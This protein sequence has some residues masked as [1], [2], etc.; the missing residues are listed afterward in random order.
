MVN[1]EMQTSSND[2]TLSTNEKSKIVTTNEN[3]EIIV[4]G[5]TI[6]QVYNLFEIKAEGYYDDYY[7]RFVIVNNEGKYEISIE[8]DWCVTN[9]ETT[10]ENGIPTI[11]LTIENDKIPTYDLQIV[12]IKKTTEST[13]SGDEKIANAE[14]DL[15]SPEVEYL[16]GA[17]F[18]LYKGTELIGD[19]TTDSQGKITIPGLY[20]YEG[21]I[22]YDQ[23]YTLK[24]VQAPSGY[25]KVQDIT[26]RAENQDGKI[27]LKEIAENGKEIESERYSIEGNTVQLI[28]EDSPSFK[29]IKKDGETKE[30]L[31]GVKFAIYNVENEQEPAR[32]SKGEIIGTK[33][34]INGEEYY[35]VE[36]NAQGEITEDL[37]AGLY[38][39]VEVQ[40]DEKYDILGNVYYFGI[41][42]SRE[43]ETKMMPTYAESIG[44]NTIVEINS[45]IDTSDGGYLVGGTFNNGKIDFGDYE[46]S[47][48]G[49]TDGFIVKY[50]ANNE[51]EWANNIGGTGNEYIYSVTET[52][53]NE[54]V[55]VGYI[56]STTVQVGDYKLDCQGSADGM[57]AKY[58]SKGEVI[59]ATNIGQKDWDEFNSVAATSDGGFVI[60]GSFNNNNITVG[61]DTYFNKGRYDGLIIKYDSSNNVAWATTIGGNSWD[62]FNSIAATSDGG[63]VIA[64]SFSSDSITIGNTSIETKGTY[65]GITI[66]YDSN[67]NVEWT[68][69]IGGSSRDEITTIDETTDG[70]IVVGGKFQS[71]NITI[72]NYTL[73]NKGSTIYN[74]GFIAKYDKE[75]EVVWANN[76]GGSNNDYVSTI[77]ATPD[78][79]ILVGGDFVSSSITIGNEQLNNSNNSN[80]SD[81]FI[82]KLDVNGQVDW[83][84]SIKGTN[85]ENVYSVLVTNNEDYLILGKTVSG[86][87]EADG[88]VLNN[89]GNG[90]GFLFKYSEKEIDS[91]ISFATTVGGNGYDEIS[92]VVE[93]V[94]KGYIVGGYF[95]KP[96]DLGGYILNNQ[97]NY[98]GMLIKYNAKGKVE[99]ATNIG[100][101]GQD[102]VT[103]IAV[104]KD[105][106]YIVGGY[107]YSDEIHV[108]DY[109]LTRTGNSG[110]SDGM[111]IKYNAKGQVEWATSIGSLGGFDWDS[112]EKVATTSDEGYIVGG[113]YQGS[114]IQVGDNTFNNN[115]NSIRSILI[116]YD[117]YGEVEWASSTNRIKNNN[118]I[119]VVAET[120]D[121]G[122]I[123]GNSETIIKYSHSGEELWKIIVS[124][125]KNVNVNSIVETEDGGYVVVGDFSNESLTVGDYTLE[126]KGSSDGFVIKYSSIGEVEWATSI[127]E[128]GNDKVLSA[129]KTKD[130]GC[131]VGGL[132]SNKNLTV[133]DYI[134]ENQGS[135]D[136][137]IIKYSSSGEVKWA[138]SFGGT[139][140]DQ[141]GSL[142]ETSDG[143]YIIGGNFNSSNISIGDYTIKNNG[144]NDGFLIKVYQNNS[145]P[146]VQELTVENNRKE[147]QITT[148]VNEINGVKGGNISGENENPYETIKHGDSTTK[149]II[150]NP[151]DGYEIIGITV[152]G[153]EYPFKA[154]SDGT[155]TM[156]VF[157]NVTENKHIE[158]TYAL[159]SNKITI[160]KIDSKTKE[161][162]SGVKFRIERIDGESTT[163]AIEI[164]TNNEGKAITQLEYGRYQITEL[165]TA[166]G[167]ELLA[168]PITVDFTRDGNSIVE[169]DNNVNV[170][171][172]E[173]GE[174][175]IEN[176]ETAK[177]IVHH[178]LKD[179]DGTYTKTKVA[180]DEIIE[181]TDKD[182]Y[183]TSPKVDLEKYELEKD[184]NGA[185]VIPKNAIGN[186]IPEETIEVTYYY[187]SK[188]IP[189]TVHYYI[190]GTEEEVPLAN[191]GT[192][193]DK[194]YVGEEGEKYTTSSISENE[195]DERYEL[196]EVPQNATGIYEYNEVIVTYYYR[197]KQSRLL[198]QKVDDSGEAVSGVTLKIVNK[199]TLREWIYE[200]DENGIIDITL[201]NGKYEITEIK[202]PEGYKLLKNPVTVDVE[203]NKENQ[204]TIEN[205]KYKEFDFNINKVDSSTGEKLTGI[206]FKLIYSTQYGEQKTEEYIT[207]ENG[208]IK[209][210]NLYAGIQYQL[211]EIETIPGYS[212]D[213]Q[214]YEFDVQYNDGE[215]ILNTQNPDLKNIQISGNQ[216]NVDIENEPSFKLIKQGTR[217]ERVEGAKFTITDEEGNEVVDGNGNL[218]GEVEE[219]NGQSLRIVTTDEN[220]EVAEALLP[221]RYIVTEVQAPEG[222][223]MPEN[224]E[225]RRKVIEVQ[226]SSKTVGI[227]K[228]NELDFDEALN[229]LDFLG[230]SIQIY[231]ISGYHNG[232]AIY[233]V[234]FDD[235]TIPKAYTSSNEEIVLERGEGIENGEDGVI[236]YI[237]Y[238]GKVEEVRQVKSEKDTINQLIYGVENQNHET[239][240]MG[241]Y[242][243]SVKISAEQT[244]SGEEKLLVNQNATY[245]NP[246]IYLI[247]Y[248]ANG[249]V[250]DLRDVTYMIDL[251]MNGPMMTAVSDKYTLLGMPNNNTFIV[252]ADETED[253]QEI[254][255]NLTD[256]NP[257]MLVLNSEGKVISAKE[258]IYMET[259]KYYTETEIQLTTG[260][261][262]VGGYPDQ[263]NI[264]FTADETESGEEL[265]LNNTVNDALLIKYNEAGKISWVSKIESEK[266]Y[267]GFEKVQEISNGYLG[268]AYFDTDLKVNT[269]SGEELNFEKQN[270]RVLIKYNLQGQIEGAYDITDDMNM[271]VDYPLITE[272]KDGYV[273]FD[274]GG[275]GIN[276]FYKE[277]NQNNIQIEPLEITV[278]NKTLET[279]NIPIS[280]VW[281]DEGNKLGKRPE[282]VIFK[283]TGSDGSEY[284]KELTVPGT[285]GSTTTQDADNEN[286]WNDIFENLPRFDQSGNRIVYTLTEEEKTEGDLKYYDIWVDTEN[287]IITNTSKYGKVTVH[288]YIMNPDGTLTT[289]K[290]PDINGTEIQDVVIEGKEGD[291][292]TT[293]E[294]NNVNDKYELVE[295]KLPEN[296]TGTIEKYDESK[297]QE[298]I[299]YY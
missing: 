126:T 28:V 23:T 281:D 159:T 256:N 177:V 120:Q 26:F 49:A 223:E 72:G 294:A 55:A 88:M 118:G 57:I 29:L 178:Y 22:E 2:S 101:N 3:G 70:G 279:L 143:S 210:P 24:E 197:L 252:P 211:Q 19:Y 195:L 192:A 39:A 66:K 257:I 60:A 82:V 201:D 80:Y 83:K 95:N 217:G 116:K 176:K 96:I 10:E 167:Y 110:Y 226:S 191:G 274:Y 78:N 185:Y 102:R 46:I 135:S 292:Y 214:V 284:T 175:V 224:E 7:S 21:Y 93:T 265:N 67:Y 266:G 48:N 230:N 132:F 268:I 107:F 131:I 267:A 212:L 150:M 261:M 125:S 111:L 134:L 219:I 68:Q 259:D 124:E 40:A 188:E 142:D 169:N 170:T 291:P 215:Y 8:N 86:S 129:S 1:L 31:A 74:D 122:Y 59:W 56:T 286:K 273:F 270:G 239:I 75:G 206:K 65:D 237:N 119:K 240:A 158:V 14:A 209:I 4:T 58:N 184:E 13:V 248:N 6:G 53:N 20:Q 103:S 154:N 202:A 204:I 293:A 236:V 90:A 52:L 140:N 155:Y 61:E 287:N 250:K 296:S 115:G 285:E 98:D 91:N 179:N 280:K 148:D 97:N 104:A 229:N 36:T 254:T 112:I 152:N 17:K 242:M 146:E 221:G 172:N 272:V 200:T 244:E 253:G 269:M 298:V 290:V 42:E 282:S 76:I 45:V 171:V 149:E 157:T 220:G 289:N 234:L 77:S 130:G 100:G 151:D 69:T 43:L 25:A 15:T 189:L 123:L 249:K 89:L 182:E 85:N 54:Y 161:P 218:V 160:S 163:N 247:T 263:N 216:I 297:P 5:L 11:T 166:E 84:S 92:T 243:N 186:F 121:G 295:E 255:I 164:T 145:I 133:G 38:K 271:F 71:N 187:V 278:I 194:T 227:S 144:Q 12:K 208:S 64:G 87:I 105:G 196:V 106:G 205:E 127:G 251:I 44:K 147:Y 190:E 225:D 246:G 193:E 262:I 213:N 275:N 37:P 228:V 81:S 35:V 108:G 33:E 41:G 299:Y 283:L 231:N 156:P 165:E 241:T 137:F 50:N 9:Q 153:E 276:I 139:S 34:T 51:V 47:S 235:L 180:E 114:S 73:N 173:M 113:Y 136:G 288:Y 109:I 181:Q 232:T 18:R 94:D 198:I 32:N 128:N 245:D 183:T 168:N 207:D 138:T 238:F 117:A 16:E 174:F 162:L 30:T 277:I 199:E 62:E 264:I 63:F 27:V 260:G 258:Y 79:G 233:G 141:V 203:I 99:W 222:Y